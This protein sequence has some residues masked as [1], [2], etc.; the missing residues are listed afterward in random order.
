MNGSIQMVGSWREWK[1]RIDPFFLATTPCR[2]FADHSCLPTDEKHS[3]DLYFDL[4][5]YN[6]DRHSSLKLGYRSPF[7]IEL[8]LM[9]PFRSSR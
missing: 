4:I 6:F 8:D 7:I 9:W 5:K 1:R 2:T 3:A